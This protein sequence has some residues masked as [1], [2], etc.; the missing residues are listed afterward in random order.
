MQGVRHG[1][2]VATTR[3]RRFSYAGT[4]G[5][6]PG[7]RAQQP[8]ERDTGFRRQRNDRVSDD[9]TSSELVEGLA[10]AALMIRDGDGV[11]RPRDLYHTATEHA[12]KL[13]TGDMGTDPK[14]SGSVRAP[15]QTLGR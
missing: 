15:S 4:H 7:R 11:K 3:L 9:R 2:A 6:A 14:P 13:L 5:S 1:G 12:R 8:Y 10:A